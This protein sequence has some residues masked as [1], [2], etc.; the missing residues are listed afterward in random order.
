MLFISRSE[1][2]R[3][4]VPKANGYTKLHAEIAEL[5]AANA[6]LEQRLLIYEEASENARQMPFMG[7][8]IEFRK[9]L[10]V[11]RKERP[12]FWSQVNNLAKET[13]D[14]CQPYGKKLV[15]AYQNVRAQLS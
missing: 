4:L 15:V 2:R 12:L 14:V 11:D 8:V 1:G 5:Q 6:E 3:S 10:K 9:G 13:L 7:Y